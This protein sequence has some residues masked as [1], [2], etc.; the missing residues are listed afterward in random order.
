MK[1]SKKVYGIALKFGL[2][3]MEYSIRIGRKGVC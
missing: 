1:M 2:A 3:G